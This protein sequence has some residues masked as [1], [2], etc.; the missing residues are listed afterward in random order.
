MLPGRRS[1]V[2][3]GAEQGCCRPAFD[4]P[5]M[6]LLIPFAA[7][8]DAAGRQALQRLP[9]AALAA[10][11]HRLQPV[12]RDEADEWSLSPPHERALARALGLVGADGCLPWAARAARADGLEPGDLAWGLVTP[13]H[14]HLGTEQVSLTDPTGLALDEA[15]SR[16]FFELVQPL[17][18]DTG[19]L[20]AWG[21]PL[22]WYLAHESLA[23]LPTASPDRVIGR[24]VDRWLGDDPAARQLRRLQAEVQML[25]HEHPLNEARAARGLPTVNSFWLSGCGVAQAATGT[26]PTVD[27]T[28][29]APALAGDWAAWAQAWERVEAQHLPALAAALDEGRPARLTLCGERATVQLAVAPPAPQR[30][31]TARWRTAL[32]GWFG[33]GA[34]RPVGPSAAHDLLEAL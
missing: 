28:L 4:N 34:S 25:L 29:R 32:G 16:A 23:T 21:A 5:A 6:H 30:G 7:P 18:T 17:F 24:N 31:L 13:A 20:F 26:L 2:G 15:E 11:C 14:W 1:A 19:C 22:R 3:R 8:L 12:W 10:L 9:L 27:D 33:R